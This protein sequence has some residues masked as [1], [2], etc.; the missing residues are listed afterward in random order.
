MG[1][2]GRLRAARTICCVEVRRVRVHCSD[3]GELAKVI[4]CGR[5]RVNR[6]G[7]RLVKR[8]Q[9]LIYIL[10]IKIFK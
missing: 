2:R 5:C 8:N 4:D 1:R 7:S 3:L 10:Q 9:M 6:E